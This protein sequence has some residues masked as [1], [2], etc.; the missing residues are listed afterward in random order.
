MSVKILDQAGLETTQQA[1]II[2]N[3]LFFK[4][5]I[6]IFLRICGVEGR[7]ID[8]EGDEEAVNRGKEVVKGDR[9]Q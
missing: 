5:Y 4:L 3:S 6:V 7:W 8:F 9:W 1:A 2:H